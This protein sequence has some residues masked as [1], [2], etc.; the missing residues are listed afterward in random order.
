[1]SKPTFIVWFRRDLRIDENPALRCAVDRGV[2]VPCFIWSPEDDGDWPP[3]GASRW[4]LHHSLIDLDNELRQRGSKLVIRQGSTCDCLEEL[5]SETKAH[6]IF[7]N[8]RYEPASLALESQVEK[9]FAKEGVENEAFNGGLLF[10]PGTILNKTDQPYKVFTSFW[11]ECLKHSVEDTVATPRIIPAPAK[12]PRCDALKD[13]QLEPKI[14]WAGGIRETWTAGSGAAKKR[15]RYFASNGLGN[16]S[17]GRN[18]IDL[19]GSSRLSPHL[20]FGEISPRQVWHAVDKSNVADSKSAS[21][22]LA[23][24]GWREFAHH[25]LYHFP[26]TTSEPLR[27]NFK[28]FPWARDARSLHNWQKGMTG[29]PIVDAAMRDLWYSGWMPNRARMIVA[30]FLTKHLLI[31]WQEGAKW[32]WDTLIDADLANNTLGWQW[33][34][35]CG[36]DAAPYFR[37]FNPVTQAE[38]FDPAANYIRQWIPEIEAMPTPHIFKPWEASDSVLRDA[39]VQ[40]GKT[41]PKPMVDHSDARQRALTAYDKIRKSKG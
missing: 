1:M 41:Y 36:A 31:S 16:Y 9:C 4:W 2:V 21:I 20:H 14:D 40:L 29:Y 26:D 27:D 6:G 35:G 28:E 39:G 17:E 33:T 34:A 18:Q 30:S 11:K 8:R 37:I 19:D 32:F 3:G 25:L 12:W 38:K 23:E 13:L 24:I 15:M 22:F 5:A 10:E 7:W